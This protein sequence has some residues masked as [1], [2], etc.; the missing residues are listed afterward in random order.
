MTPIRTDIM[1]M[2]KSN[3]HAKESFSRVEELSA[4]FCA[5]KK[6]GVPTRRYPAQNMWPQRRMARFFIYHW[7]C[8]DM[9]LSRDYCRKWVS[10]VKL[11]DKGIG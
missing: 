11:L 7:S 1:A 5:F 6:G 8:S 3:I 9:I 10:Q 2:R 4:G